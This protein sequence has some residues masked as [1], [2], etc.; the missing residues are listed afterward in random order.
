[1]MKGWGHWLVASP[2]RWLL[3]GLVIFEF[4]RTATPPLTLGI[5]L[6]VALLGTA[7]AIF[8][9][10]FF[11]IHPRGAIYLLSSLAIGP[12]LL[13]NPLFKDHWGR[14]RPSTLIAFG[15]DRTFTPALVMADQCRSNC[16]FVSGH[17]A[18]AFWMVAFALL[19]PPL[20][21]RQVILVAVS[22]G[23]FVGFVRMAQGG[24]FLS[25]V[26]FAA[27]LTI[28]VSYGVHRLIIRETGAPNV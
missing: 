28:G 5:A 15:G 27:V 22:Y 19:V 4:I 8:R 26:V 1:M 12:G 14:A 17:A 10:S 6:F 16:S 2:C 21:R 24:H 23:F 11:G 20:W 7:A 18:L 9:Q 13:A 3:P 25:D